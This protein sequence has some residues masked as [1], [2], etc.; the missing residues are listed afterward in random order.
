MKKSY[1]YHFTYQ[2]GEQH[3]ANT[4]YKF[5][6]KKSKMSEFTISTQNIDL[7]SSVFLHFKI[8]ILQQANNLEKLIDKLSNIN[9]DKWYLNTWKYD[10]SISYSQRIEITKKIASNLKN[11]GV[12]KNPNY[13]LIWCLVDNT[14]YFGILHTNKYSYKLRITKPYQ[15]SNSLPVRLAHQI[16]QLTNFLK[17]NSTIVDPCC[18]IATVIIEGLVQNKNIVGYEINPQIAKKAQ[19]NLKHF[20]FPNKVVNKDMLLLKKHYDVAIIDIPYGLYNFF[21]NNKQKEIL[22]H[23]INICKYLILI[24]IDDFNDYC[25]NQGYKK[26]LQTS[27][28]KGKFTRFITVFQADS[29]N[30]TLYN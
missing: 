7:E 29:T 11:K 27:T 23:S 1:I 17:H 8:E 30:H 2:D 21:D 12:M 22:A 9:L 4:F 25:Y 18:G 6:F 5:M 20:N 24:S 19:E 14:Y 15:Y 16:I 10:K 26:I 13:Q 3:L 28:T